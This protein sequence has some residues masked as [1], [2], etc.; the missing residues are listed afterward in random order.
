[1]IDDGAVDGVDCIFC[2]HIWA[3]VP[4]GKVSVEAGPRMACA[5]WFYIN[6]KGK[7]GHGSQPENCIH[8]LVESS[9][10]VM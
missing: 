7:G 5:D 3:Q 9:A 6:V 2:I 1:M 10:I 8:A 4:V